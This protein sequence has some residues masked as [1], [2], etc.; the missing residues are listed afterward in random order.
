M[1]HN[2]DII[3][4]TCSYHEMTVKEGTTERQIYISVNN[5]KRQH[6]HKTARL[7]TGKLVHFART[8]HRGC[9]DFSSTYIFDFLVRVFSVIW[10]FNFLH[11]DK[12]MSFDA[13]EQSFD[14]DKVVGKRNKNGMVSLLFLLFSQISR[15]IGFCLCNTLFE[16]IQISLNF[17]RLLG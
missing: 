3:V 11:F 16:K 12:K 4:K 14:V 8:L 9:Y 13:S 2:N 5:R 1:V 17:V 15:M 7:Q 10:S 6:L